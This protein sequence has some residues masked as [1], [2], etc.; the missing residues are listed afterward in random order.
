MMRILL[1]PRRYFIRKVYRESLP[2]LRLIDEMTEDLALAFE[3]FGL[4]RMTQMLEPK[5]AE[6][7]KLRLK[8]PTLFV[9]GEHEVIYP[10]QDASPGSPRGSSG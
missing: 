3:C 7:E 1:P 4:R 10:A 5:V 9:I 6:D 8:V 2:G